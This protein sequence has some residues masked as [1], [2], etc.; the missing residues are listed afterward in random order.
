MSIC[1]N[2]WY[3]RFESSRK[4]SRRLGW[5][6]KKSEAVG[7]GRKKSGAVGTSRKKSGAVGTG[8]K[9]SNRLGQSRDTRIQSSSAALSGRVVRGR[10]D[11]ATTRRMRQ[12]S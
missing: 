5:A 6:R 1:S 2:S 12:L 7:T 4:K 9:Q 3:V 10:M 11:S 8:R